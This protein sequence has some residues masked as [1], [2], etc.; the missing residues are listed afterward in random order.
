MRP[1]IVFDRSRE[2]TGPTTPALL[3][4]EGSCGRKPRW[5]ALARKEN[6]RVASAEG[7]YMRIIYECTVCGTFRVWGTEEL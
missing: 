2:S 3:M 6:H 4:C 1:I 5:H 7:A